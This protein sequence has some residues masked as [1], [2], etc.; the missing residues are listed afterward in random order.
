MDRNKIK[1]IVLDTLTK[2]LGVDREKMEANPNLDLQADLGCDSVRAF[3]I[4]SM[5]EDELDVEIPYDDFRRAGAIESTIN[6][7]VGCCEKED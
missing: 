6:F 5:L 4:I 3:T 2:G 1:N 7:I